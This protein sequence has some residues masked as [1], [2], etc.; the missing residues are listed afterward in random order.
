MQHLKIYFPAA[1]PAKPERNLPKTVV[2]T[3]N[4]ESAAVGNMLKN[5]AVSANP[6]PP[7][8]PATSSSQ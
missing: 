7:T 4:A 3:P 1:Y 8:A 6:A 5:L 2:P